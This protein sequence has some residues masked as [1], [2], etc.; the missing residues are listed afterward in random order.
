MK[1]ARLDGL[2]ATYQCRIEAGMVL[3]H[4]LFQTDGHGASFGASAIIARFRPARTRKI[5]V[6]IT[7]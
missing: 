2:A 4:F 5:M 1:K 3:L 6:E 7:L